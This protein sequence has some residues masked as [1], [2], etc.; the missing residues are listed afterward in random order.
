[1]VKEEVLDFFGEFYENGRFVRSLSAIFPKKGGK[2]GGGK[3]L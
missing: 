2:G 1:M 3:G